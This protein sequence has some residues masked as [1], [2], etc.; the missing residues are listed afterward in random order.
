MSRKHTV[1][2]VAL[3]A[4]AASLFASLATTAKAGNTG[5]GTGQQYGDASVSCSQWIRL[6]DDPNE[7]K[8]PWPENL[9][10]RYASWTTGFVS[11]ASSVN[12][13][14]RATSAVHIIQFVTKLLHG[15]PQKFNRTGK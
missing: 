5:D 14:L 15:A 2:R 11:G 9:F 8:K 7:M 10:Y 13:K 4:C 12:P 1:N 6:H 3:L